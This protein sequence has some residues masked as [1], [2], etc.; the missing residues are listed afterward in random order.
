MKVTVIGA[1]SAFSVGEYKDA[2]PVKK[3]AEL[4]PEVSKR[5]KNAGAKPDEIN[6]YLESFIEEHTEKLYSSAW[7]SNFLIEFDQRNIR[8]DDSPFRLV[9]DFGSDVRHALVRTGLDFKDIDAYYV[10]H[11]HDD[12]IGGVEGIALKTFFNPYFTKKKIAWLDGENIIDK[13]TYKAARGQLYKVPKEA[14]PLM[15]GHRDILEALWQSAKPG[16]LTLQQV[17][18]VTLNTYFD[19]K[20]MVENEPLI[21]K[22]GKRT[23]N[24]YIVLS[25]HVVSGDSTMPSY[26]LIFESDETIVFFPT[27]TQFMVPPQLRGHYMKSDHI[28]HDTETSPFPSGVHTRLEELRTLPADLKKKMIL[29]HYDATLPPNVEKG[30]FRDIARAGST[31]EF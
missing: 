25:M 30:E 28:F 5:M 9:L 3:L 1:N 4:I 24:A 8:G 20:E 29:Y 12:H 27:D 10:S 26:G 15:L 16:L 23:W 13:I 31:Y 22:D 6:Q 14:K 19:T 18:E 11:P 2:V 7:Q 21:L 17:R